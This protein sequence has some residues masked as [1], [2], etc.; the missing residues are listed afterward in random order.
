VKWCYKETTSTQE[1]V[2]NDKGEKEKVEEVS[3]LG[4]VEVQVVNDM[5]DVEKEPLKA[6]PQQAKHREIDRTK[7]KYSL[8]LQEQNALATAKKKDKLEAQNIAV[9]RRKK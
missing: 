9:N 5:A 1:V 2:T 3:K 6:P 7:T 8:R 4:L